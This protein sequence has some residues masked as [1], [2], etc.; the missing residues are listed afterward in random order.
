MKRTKL[1]AAL[2]ASALALATLGAQSAAHA[3][4][5]YVG[6]MQQFG[7]DW[8]PRGWLRA[9][10]TLLSISVY[11]AL[12]SLIGTTYGGDGV[13]TFALP[14]LQDRWPISWSSTYPI[15]AVAGNSQITLTTNQ[16]PIHGHSF[17]ADP[18]G[19]V[20]PDPTD[21]ML[22]L[23]PTGQNIYAATTATPTV[24][25]NPAATTISGGSMPVQ[26]Q[27]PTLVT[28]WCIATE[29]VYP[30]RP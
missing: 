16:M 24:G 2:A 15:G 12:Y 29:G 11:D 23:F 21:S 6:Q 9:D 25:L 14:N 22:G 30:Q 13:T 5:F 4:E 26:V 18:T 28:N 10:G 20:G 27:S 7:T 17:S 1:H 3:Q 8:C 19:P